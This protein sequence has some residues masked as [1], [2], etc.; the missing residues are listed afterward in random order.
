MLGDRREDDEAYVIEVRGD[1]P[2]YQVHLACGRVLDMGY[3]TLYS[4]RRFQRAVEAATGRW[5]YFRSLGARE[6]TRRQ[7]G[8]FVDGKRRPTQ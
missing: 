1:P 7:W 4:R 3:D 2:R 5:L 6:M 8:S